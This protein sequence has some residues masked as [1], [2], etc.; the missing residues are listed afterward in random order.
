M[1]LRGAWKKGESGNS[2]GRALG[3]RNKLTEAFLKA[4]NDDFQVHGPTVIEQVRETRPEVY[5]KIVAAI[6]PREL[7]M[8]SESAL[9]GLSDEHLNDI[10]GA[11]RRQLSAR[12]GS[13]SGAGGN[14][15]QS[16]N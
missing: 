10:L 16:I 9:S 7:H 11:V 2:A 4:L 1:G 15:P 6:L 12:A 8:K 3:S 5:L 14:T 13:G